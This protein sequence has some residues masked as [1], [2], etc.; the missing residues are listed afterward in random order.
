[1]RLFHW[2]PFTTRTTFAMQRNKRNPVASVT[3][4]L[5]S[6]PP[7]ASH[8]KHA[9]HCNDFYFSSKIIVESCESVS[10]KNTT[11]MCEWKF[12]FQGPNTHINSG[13]FFHFVFFKNPDQK[14]ESKSESKKAKKQKQKAKA[15]IK[16]TIE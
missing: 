3:K 6:N 14:V 8:P 9:T 4:L 15:K 7:C 1:M 13:V 12:L 10:G 5:H 11:K 2:C 16:Q